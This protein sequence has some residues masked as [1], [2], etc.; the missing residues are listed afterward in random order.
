MNLAIGNMLIPIKFDY[1]ARA[2]LFWVVMLATGAPDR[3][4][5]NDAMLELK[6]GYEAQVVF[7]NTLPSGNRTAAIE[8]VSSSSVLMNEPSAPY[9]VLGLG[10]SYDGQSLTELTD[11]YSSEAASTTNV[12]RTARGGESKL[13]DADTADFSAVMHVAPM[14]SVASELANARDVASMVEPLIVESTDVLHEISKEE[15]VPALRKPRRVPPIYAVLS[16]IAA[17][18][19]YLMLVVVRCMGMLEALSPKKALCE[20]MSLEVGTEASSEEVAAPFAW[21]SRFRKARRGGPARFC[22]PSSCE[23]SSCG[24]LCAESEK[25]P[26]LVDDHLP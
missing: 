2:L 4:Q 22:R 14:P 10:D 3:Q 11:G 1:R 6:S 23:D 5:S 16:T 26:P 9:H 21:S 25:C 7:I 19:A 20:I 12:I 13:M 8:I 18:C 24:S 17:S 15:S